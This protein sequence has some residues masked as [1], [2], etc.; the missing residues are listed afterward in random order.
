MDDADDNDDQ[1]DPYHGQFFYD[2]ASTVKS[3]VNNSLQ[4]KV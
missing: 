2:E 4:N 3:C 1:I